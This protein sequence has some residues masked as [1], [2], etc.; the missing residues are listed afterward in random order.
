LAALAVLACA[1]DSSSNTKAAR[2]ERYVAKLRECGLLTKQGELKFEPNEGH[3]CAMDCRAE[4]SCAD[5]TH[6]ECNEGGEEWSSALDQCFFNC[7]DSELEPGNAFECENGDSTEAYYCDGWSSCLDGSDER[8]CPKGTAFLC[9]DGMSIGKDDECDGFE[10][11]EDGSDEV[12]C[13]QRG[14]AFACDD[15]EYVAK[16]DVCDGWEA[17]FDGSDE[18]QG[19]AQY[20]CAD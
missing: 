15:G 12:D 6:F 8:G 13:I 18:R 11:C 1:S 20:L 19:C 14:L 7:A 2:V 9:S 16:A 17:C 10:D 4:A 3:Y 5:L